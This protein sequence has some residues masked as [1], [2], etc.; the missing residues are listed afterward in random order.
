MC[1]RTQIRRV[2]YTDEQIKK[3]NF[4]FH[5]FRFFV[6]SMKQLKMY[7]NYMHSVICNFCIKFNSLLSEKC[8]LL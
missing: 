2:L 5:H 3:K 8:F 7:Q 4:K 6:I 1:S